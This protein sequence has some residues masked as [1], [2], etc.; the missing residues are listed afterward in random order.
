MKLS[1]YRCSAR[2]CMMDSNAIS[3]KSSERG[4]EIYAR[5]HALVVLLFSLLLLR[6]T[7]DTSSE[8]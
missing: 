6:E 8:A 5:V 7:Y 2:A 3:I 4:K 1:C